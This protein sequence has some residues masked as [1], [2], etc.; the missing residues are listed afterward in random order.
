MAERTRI[1]QYWHPVAE[2]DDVGPTPLAVE[3]LG[4][5]IVLFRNADD[6][7]VALRDL[8]VH[9]GAPLS[10]GTVVGGTLMCAYHGWRYGDDGRVVTIPCLREGGSIPRAARTPSYLVEERYTLVWVALEDPVLPIPDIPGEVL[11]EPDVHSR[12]W[13]NFDWKTSAGRA[14]ENAMDLAHFPFVHPYLLADPDAPAVLDYEIK[15]TPS[16]VSFRT[17]RFRYAEPGQPEATGWAE[18]THDFPFTEHLRLV[19]P[20]PDGDGEVTTVLSAFHS[21]TAD[22]RTRIWRVAHK[23][24]P[25]TAD[26]DSQIDLFLKILEQDRVIAESVRPEMI[27]TDL[28]EEL[29]LKVPDAQS[30][31]FR[32]W[33]GT[34]DML[35]VKLP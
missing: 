9:R 24:G 21:P 2:A 18:Y 13:A 3:L 17:G 35:G 15:T 6:E 10:M 4:Q 26:D 31:A 32:Q 34:V 1:S 20:A 12:C 25:F 8:C 5:S 7:I 27:P 23:T 14:V 22:D 30:V 33:L 19:E 29:H 16:S 28:R 11:A